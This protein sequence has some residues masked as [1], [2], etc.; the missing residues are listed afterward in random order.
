MKM[1]SDIKT[2]KIKSCSQDRG[3]ALKVND[4]I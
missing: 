1:F 2:I 3:L 4:L